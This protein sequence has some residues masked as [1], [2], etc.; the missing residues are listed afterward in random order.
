MTSLFFLFLS[1]QFFSHNFD[2]T[3]PNHLLMFNFHERCQKAFWILFCSYP[4][5][6]QIN[7]W[8]A[9]QED[10]H[11]F[12]KW[13]QYRDCLL[14]FYSV[15]LDLHELLIVLNQKRQICSSKSF[16][17]SA[18]KTKRSVCSKYSIFRYKS[19][20]IID[21][22]WIQPILIPIYFCGA[23]KKSAT[24]SLFWVGSRLKI[25]SRFN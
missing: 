10:F 24:S 6:I 16:S 22:L 5:F 20:I 3:I 25:D 14:R 11:T 8:L 17:S 2:W 12:F 7:W 18:A 19:T 9:Y 15:S 4:N 23:I 21:R 1:V 13:T